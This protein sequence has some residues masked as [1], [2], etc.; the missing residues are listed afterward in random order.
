MTQPQLERATEKLGP[1]RRVGQSYLS[2][3]ERGD[4]PLEGVDPF[5]REALRFALR[6]SYADWER[7]TGDRIPTGARLPTRDDVTRDAENRPAVS[8]RADNV[9][10]QD[11]EEAD[12]YSFASA[13]LL[14]TD[15]QEPQVIARRPVKPQYNNHGK[16]IFRVVGQSMEPTIWEGEDIVVDTED[17]NLEDDAVYLI[18][19]PNGDVV[20]KRVRWE[21]GERWLFSD[22]PDQRRY[23]PTRIEQGTVVRG[24]VIKALPQERD[25]L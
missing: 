7:M 11:W 3:I 23:R 22:N 13:S 12:V 6:I 20:V 2:K 14:T 15:P 1:D 16:R 17:L 5:R 19:I 25:V 4:Q 24:R 18:A 10:E 9:V 8:Y 21:D